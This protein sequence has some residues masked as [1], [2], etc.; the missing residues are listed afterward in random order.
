MRILHVI[1][2]V[3]G[4][5]SLHVGIVAEMQQRSGHE[6]AVALPD[7][8]AWGLSDPQL[9]PALRRSGVT[10]YRIPF[11]TLPLHGRN[12]L[13]ARE[14]AR[15]AREWSPDLIHSHS[16]TAGFIA[17]PVA[18]RLGIPSVHTPNGVRFA[19]QRRGLPWIGEWAIERLL[20]PITGKVVAV[21]PSEAQVLGRMYPPERIAVVSNAIPVPDEVP[22]M[23][24]R[25]RVV[26]VNRLVYQK[27]PATTVRTMALARRRR[28]NLEAIIVGD[29]VLEKKI[30]SLVRELDPGINLAGT[31]MEGRSAIAGS[32]MLL[33]TSRWEGAPF[34]LLEA[35]GFARPIIASDVVGTKDVVE[36]DV[37]GYLFPG[38]DAHAAADYLVQLVDDPSKASDMGAAGRHRLQVCFSPDRLIDDLDEAYRA[39]RRESG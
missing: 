31:T 3:G 19:D 21:S 25:P 35:M 27:D 18:R 33:L 7:R 29:G 4:G 16:M 38:G 20:A 2:A 39:V 24:A 34:V 1:E 11:H 37:T 28:P 17:R 8:R 32:S 13:A 10:V 36:H 30:S 9:I 5:L 15:H 22:A 14:L 23:P 6:V 12:A 26:A